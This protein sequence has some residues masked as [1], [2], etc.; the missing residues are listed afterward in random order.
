MSVEFVSPSGLKKY[1]ENIKEYI[2][3]KYVQKENITITLDEYSTNDQIPSAKAVYDALKNEKTPSIDDIEITITADAWELD[4]TENTYK[5]TITIEGL[6]PNDNPIV[7]LGSIES[8]E[9]LN[10]FALID[11]MM[12]D[13]NNI[14]FI[15]SQALST[16]ISVIIKDA[17]SSSSNKNDIKVTLFAN[18]WEKDVSNNIYKQ[19]IT[20]EG[21]STNDNP[22]VV[23]SQTG[24]DVTD[25]E[26]DA[27]A[28]VD[29]IMLSN[30]SIICTSSEA[31][32]IDINVIIKDVMDI[33]DN[34]ND[35]EI[36]LVNNLWEEDVTNNTY[37]QIIVME[38]LS[39]NDNPIVMLNPMEN[40]AT[41]AEL[42]AFNLIDNVMI[43]NNSIVCTAREALSIDLN[44]IVKDIVAI[45]NNNN[46]SNDNINIDDF[47][48]RFNDL[49]TSIND[50][51]NAVEHCYNLDDP[52]RIPNGTDVLTLTDYKCYYC[53]DKSHALTLVN[54]PT[55]ESGFSYRYER[56]NGSKDGTQ[57]IAIAVTTYGVEYRAVQTP[58]GW[59][60]WIKTPIASNLENNMA[61][62]SNSKGFIKTSNVTETELNYLA[63]TTDNIQ[64]QL[65]NMAD[66]IEHCY[67]LDNA[68]RIPN[69]TD[70]HTL[71]DFKIYYCGN[72]EH[73]ATLINAPVTT[74][75]FS[76]RYEKVNG[77][78]G[79]Y[80]IATVI[81]TGGTEYRSV[82]MDNEWGEWIKTPINSNLDDNT[83]LISS[84]NG[85]IKSSAVTATELNRL[86]GATSN[87]QTQLNEKQSTITGAA[88]SI[89]NNDLTESMAMVTTTA[90]KVGVS[91]KVTATE[92]NR[93]SGVTSNVQS[94]IDSFKPIIV[95]PT[96]VLE[97]I[98]DNASACLAKIVVYPY[99]KKVELRVRFTRAFTSSGDGITTYKLGK[100]TDYVPSITQA[101]CAYAPIANKDAW[102]V[103]SGI[104]D[105][106]EIFIALKGATNPTYFY[107]NGS[108]FY[109]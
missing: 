6:S 106:G 35:V 99:E 102:I 85:F 84:G 53:G 78:L 2:C 82:R 28:L 100:M 89:I 104:N 80:G 98:T 15:A 71:T 25:E 70:I 52:I 16:N 72:A 107:L 77:S 14:T 61:L 26:L 7:I 75:G 33:S 83:V 20:M 39:T 9:E 21:L 1:D 74:A 66:D 12:I 76:Y 105:D 62:V 109:G 65:D 91:S 93:L 58:N 50:L 95:S 60:E 32:P 57:G 34:A 59:G 68:E 87:I 36:T 3:D 47:E 88:T 103:G 27:F 41:D 51:N 17:M 63:G 24:S 5:Q 108:Y 92:L 43:N 69:G 8:D 86:S 79:A 46:N 22:L 31:L 97:P 56:T 64:S 10:A 55:Q 90:G 29:N 23:L 96:G 4:A 11:K 49:E 37:K 94:Q 45:E 38:G 81:T 48:L 18:S 30:N 54:A 67:R 19:I 13:N 44:V 42:N 73:A 101:L 40:V